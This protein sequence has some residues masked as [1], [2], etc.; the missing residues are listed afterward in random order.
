[1]SDV[2]LFLFLQNTLIANVP[3]KLELRKLYV[4]KRTAV[5]NVGSAVFHVLLFR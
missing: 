3:C 4:Y 5:T 1:M 2:E